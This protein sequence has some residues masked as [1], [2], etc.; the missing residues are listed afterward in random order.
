M[1]LHGRLPC[2]ALADAAWEG[3]GLTG[4]GRAKGDAAL[5]LQAP[6]SVLEHPST[7]PGKR[8]RSWHKLKQT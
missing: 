8:G 5:P 2:R 7:K 4:K 1:A 6:Y 3:A